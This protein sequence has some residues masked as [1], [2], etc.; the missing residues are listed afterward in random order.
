MLQTSTDIV[1]FSLLLKS[2][3][4]LDDATVSG[5]LKSVLWN[6]KGYYNKIR[7]KEIDLD[8]DFFYLI[9]RFEFNAD[10]FSVYL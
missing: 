2:Q 7:K 10:I 9:S 4:I 6:V 1:K 8:F 3:S 5:I